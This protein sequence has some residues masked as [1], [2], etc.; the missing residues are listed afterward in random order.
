MKLKS[1]FVILLFT[2]SSASIAKDIV[3]GESGYHA[4]E[5]WNAIQ[6]G[7]AFFKLKGVNNGCGLENEWQ[8]NN[9][10]MQTVL[11]MISIDETEVNLICKDSL[12]VDFEIKE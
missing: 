8:V 4:I 9:F 2:I 12:V 6:Y 7:P 10:M 11:K 1:L 3:N 5:D